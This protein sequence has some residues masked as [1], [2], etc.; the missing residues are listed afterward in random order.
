MRDAMQAYASW[1]PGRVNDT[2]TPREA[3]WVFVQLFASSFSETY[4]PHL[5]WEDLSQK[6]RFEDLDPRE[7]LANAKEMGL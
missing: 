5:G 2:V 7:E 1:L 3:H 6:L 4:R